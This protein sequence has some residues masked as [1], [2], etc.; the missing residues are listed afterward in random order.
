MTTEGT[1]AEAFYKHCLLDVKLLLN[2][3]CVPDISCIYL[4]KQNIPCI[5]HLLSGSG[6]AAELYKGG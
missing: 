3:E 4:V 2:S 6:S 1:V 5:P